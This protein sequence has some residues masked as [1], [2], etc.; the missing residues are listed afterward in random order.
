MGSK[1]GRR[2]FLPLPKLTEIL[3][4][5]WAGLFYST[6]VRE[7]FPQGYAS[8]VSLYFYS[9]SAL[10]MTIPVYVFF[11]LWTW[12]GVKLFKCNQCNHSGDSKY[13]NDRS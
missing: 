8:M 9:Q 13:I 3:L 6:S 4:I 2:V 11:H 5:P 12:M 7:N 1:W 10:V